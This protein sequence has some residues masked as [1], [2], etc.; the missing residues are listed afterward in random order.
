MDNEHH[1]HDV[2]TIAGDGS[3]GFRDGRGTQSQFN[4]PCGVAVDN[5]NNII[6]A[7][8]CNNRI[9]RISPDGDV[10]TIAGDGSRGFRDGRGTQ[11]QFNGPSGV[12]V[13]NNNNII[14]ADKQNNR[15]RR[16]SPDGDV[17]TIAGDG[18]GGF[19]DGR[20]TQSQFNQP[21]GVAV[22]NN[23]NIIVADACNNRIRRISPDGDV[24][25]A[26][27]TR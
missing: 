7:D 26:Q 13:D 16:I 21:Y 9:R 15:I 23:N 8:T 20:G 27:D 11:S 1:P 6:V 24:I 10:T 18:S 14:V 25:V 3:I 12:A 22:D 19:R 2:T 4:R 17:T 5:N